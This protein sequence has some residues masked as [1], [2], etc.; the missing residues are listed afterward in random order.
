MKKPSENSNPTAFLLDAT[1]VLSKVDKNMDDFFTKY[2]LM[3]NIHL[4]IS[5]RELRYKCK[6]K[7]GGVG[8]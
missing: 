6:K 2:F 5:E 1:E 7:K 3:N 4:K 8:H